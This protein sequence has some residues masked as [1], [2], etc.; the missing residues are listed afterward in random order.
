MK[1][2][3]PATFADVLVRL[4]QL[5]DLSPTRR[6]DMMSAVRRIAGLLGRGPETIPANLRSIRSAL[7]QVHPAQQTP[8]LSPKT[9]INLRSN[10]LKALHLTGAPATPRGSRLAHPWEGLFAALPDAASRTGLSQFLRYLS[11]ASAPPET[12]SDATLVGFADHLRDTTLLRP[13]RQ[14]EL[15]RTAAKAWNLAAVTIAGWPPHLL[16]VPS[17]RK[18]RQTLHLD[19][20]PRSLRAEIEAYLQWTAGADPF[21]APPRPSRPL[22]QALERSN[23]QLAVSAWVHR[24]HPLEELQSL[25]DLVEP[26][27][28]REILRH[29]ITK[30]AVAGEAGKARPTAHAIAKLLLKIAHRWVKVGVDQMEALR[31]ISRRLGPERSGLTV[32]NR[33]MLRQFDAPENVQLLLALPDTLMREA[34]ALPKG[35]VH[36]A[37]LMQT[38]VVIEILLM[39]PIRSKNLAGLRF[40]HSLVRPGGK[41]GP[42]HIRL[43]EAETKTSEPLEYPL[44]DRLSAMIDEYRR[45]YRPALVNGTDAGYLLPSTMNDQKGQSTIALQTRKQIRKRTGLR[46]SLHQFRH[47]AAKILLD[48]A[49]GNYQ[50]ASHLLGHANPKTTVKMYTGLRTQAAA[51]YFD[52]LVEKLRLKKENAP[53]EALS[54]NEPRTVRKLRRKP[55]KQPAKDE[56]SHDE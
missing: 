9:W 25:R 17:Y 10:L 7:E 40:G 5:P 12:I 45:R 37:V 50:A 21:N 11:A 28:V 31:T 20:M 35:S 4:Q 54:R 19:Q 13:A 26:V 18:P 1:D 33:D 30:P 29:Y 22:T 32:K 55:G 42:W 23:L 43:E 41:T 48:A 34:A 24:G 27:R 2:P 46:M 15:I 52:D 14:R 53:L 6:R 39:A 47:L 38:A 8:P 44:P 49:P 56:P 51:R 3:V 36:A 16:A